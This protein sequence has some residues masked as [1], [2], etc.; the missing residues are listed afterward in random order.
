VEELEICDKVF[1]I[2]DSTSWNPCNEGYSINEDSMTDFDGTMSTFTHKIHDLLDGSQ[3]MYEVL[4]S[5]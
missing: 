4:S 1:I 5:I 3:D 2:P